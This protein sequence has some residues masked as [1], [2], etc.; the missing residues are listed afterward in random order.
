MSF[1]RLAAGGW[2]SEKTSDGK[3]PFQWVSREPHWWIYSV[4]GRGGAE[5]RLAPTR[6]N[7]L[8]TGKQLKQGLEVAVSERVTFADGD[9][10]L[11]LEPPHK[12]WVPILR[13]NGETKMMPEREIPAGNTP[14]PVQELP[15]FLQSGQT[16]P[17]QRPKKFGFKRGIKKGVKNMLGKKNPHHQRASATE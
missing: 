1:Y 4:S 13:Q 12:G 5:C 7:K 11:H 9:S 2:I 10:F 15:P 8:K 6:D 16:S 3:S 14:D 17:G